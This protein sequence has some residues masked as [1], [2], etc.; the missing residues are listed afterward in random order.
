MDIFLLE[1]ISFGI[2]QDRVTILA[3]YTCLVSPIPPFLVYPY[4][5][6]SCRMHSLL[7]ES[8]IANL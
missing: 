7:F 5:S 4:V 6:S 8:A 1:A 3:A 2:E